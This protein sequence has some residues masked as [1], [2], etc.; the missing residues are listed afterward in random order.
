MIVGTSRTKAPA[1]L[2]RFTV[3]FQLVERDG[4]V[5]ASQ[6]ALITRPARINPLASASIDHSDRRLKLNYRGVEHGATAG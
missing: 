3:R 6:I 4:Q 2:L 5:L 1:Y